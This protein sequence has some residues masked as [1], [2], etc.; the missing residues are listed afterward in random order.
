MNVALEL[1]QIFSSLISCKLGPKISTMYANILQDSSDTRAGG[2]NSEMD[3]SQWDSDHHVTYVADKLDKM[4][5]VNFVRNTEWVE[6]HKV[7]V[8]T[9]ITTALK[10]CT[11]QNDQAL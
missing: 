10:Y 1:S 11:Y 3:F 6:T 8:Q 9:S 2:S 7:P 4:G 5:H